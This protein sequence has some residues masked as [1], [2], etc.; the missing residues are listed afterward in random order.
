MAVRKRRKSSTH[1]TASSALNAAVSARS[2]P[3]QN[4]LHA[5]SHTV[6][7]GSQPGSTKAPL[8]GI[9]VCAYDKSEGSCV[10][11]VCGGVSHQNYQCIVDSCPDSG[12]ITTN[13][14]G[15]SEK[16]GNWA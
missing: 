3:A 1:A 12:C 13:S 11:T 8:V 4:A 7:S 10:F 9:K 16:S 5:N 14:S 2:L 15:E 6:G